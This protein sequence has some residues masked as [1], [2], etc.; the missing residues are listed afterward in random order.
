MRH[1]LG[2]DLETPLTIQRGTPY[3]S[4][5][6]SWAVGLNISRW[7]YDRDVGWVC[8]ALPASPDPDYEPGV[9]GDAR[10]PVAADAAL[11]SSLFTCQPNVVSA[12]V[13]PPNIRK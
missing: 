10:K 4:F 6:K 1:L 12:S 3:L 9:P 11:A 5:S 13:V 7:R 2:A 8:Q